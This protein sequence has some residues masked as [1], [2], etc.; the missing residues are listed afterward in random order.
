MKN[1][2]F[3]YTLLSFVGTAM[4][5]M[6]AERAQSQTVVKIGEAEIAIQSP[7]SV[8]KRDTT[9]VNFYQNET[10]PQRGATGVKKARY[11]RNSQEFFIGIG[12][13]VPTS[14]EE[15]LPMHYGNS[16]SLEA[17]FKYF[18][19]TGS[20][21]DIGTIFQYTCYTYKTKG[22]AAD[23][24]FFSN[25][26]GEVKKEY[27]RTDNL[28][29]GIINRFYLF[30]MKGRP[31]MLD[32]GGYADFSYSKRFNVKTIENG[33][34]NK[35]KYRDGSK[36]NPVQAGLYGAISKGKYSFYARY[37]LTNLFNPK[38]VPLE[39]PRLCLGLQ[40]SMD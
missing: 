23:E 4:L 13:T 25:I 29:T 36:F 37:R 14:N 9:Q 3:K 32:L 22:A 21:Y 20:R 8:R 34:Q 31:F 5:M 30:P 18:H 11:P 2:R 27:F 38:E 26:P 40:I 7:I 35:Y 10:K 6:T 33:K 39:L 1:Y 15:F 19:R 24:T 17:G 28:G 12:M 16:Y